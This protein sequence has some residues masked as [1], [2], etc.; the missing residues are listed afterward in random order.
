MATQKRVERNLYT[1]LVAS[2]FPLS[3]NNL[4]NMIDI[5]NF[6]WIYILESG[7]GEVFV[8]APNPC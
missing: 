5:F 6:V 3:T 2:P 1:L 4:E 8:A 7:E